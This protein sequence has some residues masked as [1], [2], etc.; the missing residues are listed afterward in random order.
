M[1]PAIPGYGWSQSLQVGFAQFVVVPDRVAEVGQ[2]AGG[3]CQT[4]FE[5]KHG[6]GLILGDYLRQA[7]GLEPGSLGESGAADGGVETIQLR[8][9]DKQ[10]LLAGTSD[11]V[12]IGVGVVI[13]IT[14]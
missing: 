9:R 7:R 6:V 11:L 2:L 10:I 12:G 8:E 1:E 14:V 4:G 3:L 5:V 13:I